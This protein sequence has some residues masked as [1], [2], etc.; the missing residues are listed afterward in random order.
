MTASKVCLSCQAPQVQ[1]HFLFLTLHLFP[2]QLKQ[3]CTI[4]NSLGEQHH[5][6]R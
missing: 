3:I 6:L 5:L 1:G 4:A 2:G